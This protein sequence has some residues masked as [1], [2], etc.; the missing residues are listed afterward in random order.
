MAQRVFVKAASSLARLSGNEAVTVKTLHF[1]SAAAE[2]L[3]GGRRVH[4]N[5]KK[6]QRHISSRMGGSYSPAISC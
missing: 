4:K 5:G 3:L 6:Y 2:E 1:C